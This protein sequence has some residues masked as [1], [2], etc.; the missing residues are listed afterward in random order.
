VDYDSVP[1]IPAAEFRFGNA[2]GDASFAPGV[3]DE[4]EIVRAHPILASG[5]V[6]G[7]ASEYLADSVPAKNFILNFQ[8]VD[9]TTRR[10]R[11]LHFGATS[12]F[13]GLNVGLATA[14]VGVP[15]GALEWEYWDGAEWA[16]LESVAGFTDTTNSF[17]RS[18]NVYW[19]ADPPGW[20]RFSIFGGVDTFRIRVHLAAG[21]SYSTFTVTRTSD[22]NPAQGSPR[23]PRC[24]GSPAAPSRSTPGPS[25]W[26]HP[27]PRK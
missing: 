4:I 27:S 14:G 23:P 13:R 12:K 15:A 24:S 10:G 2:D 9:A 16:S 17:T 8:P 6:V 25:P 26:R 19:T 18:G 22:S 7:D 3:Y 1:L 20:A 21:S 11:Y 5:G